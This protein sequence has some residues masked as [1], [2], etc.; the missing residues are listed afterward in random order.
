M[1]SDGL[2]PPPLSWPLDVRD[3]PSGGLKGKRE[4]TARELA[5]LATFLDLLEV[6]RVAI[7]Y[8][9]IAKG[10]GKARLRGR[11]AAD[12]DQACVITQ[13]PVP[14]RIDESFDLEYWPPEDLVKATA[15]AA[16][17]AAAPEP[18]EPLIDG[19][20]DAGALATE[21]LAVALDPY[22]RAPGAEFN[23]PEEPRAGNP[24][25]ALA[26]LKPR[27]PG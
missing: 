16:L 13:E 27:G 21:L 18:P 8:T 6:R 2:P 10:G 15:D 22:P 5:A 20:V 3:V 12:V 14:A 11:L 1:Q 19:R 17:D 7:E 23:P 25:E 9:L 24:F 26:K 4:A